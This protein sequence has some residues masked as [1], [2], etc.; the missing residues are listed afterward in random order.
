MSAIP[1][2]RLF[3]SKHVNIIFIEYLRCNFLDIGYD[4]MFILMNTLEL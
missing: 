4:F 3:I 1:V 2:K